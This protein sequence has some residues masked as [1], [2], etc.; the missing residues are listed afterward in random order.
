MTDRTVSRC[1][2]SM[3]FRPEN[4]DQKKGDCQEKKKKLRFKIFTIFFDKQNI[5]KKN[6]FFSNDRC[7]NMEKTIK[8]LSEKN[9][10]VR[11]LHGFTYIKTILFESS[12]IRLLIKTIPSNMY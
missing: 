10:Q 8:G 6:L 3:N 2:R 1:I 4:S 12:V 11:D 5:E 9:L 7:L